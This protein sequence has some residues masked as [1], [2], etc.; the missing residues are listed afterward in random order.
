MTE[1]QKKILMLY[2]KMEKYFSKKSYIDI[3]LYAGIDEDIHNICSD[4]V[5][6]V[7]EMLDIDAEECQLLYDAAYNGFP[8]ASTFI[9]IDTN[10]QEKITCNTIEEFILTFFSDN[11][12]EN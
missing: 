11:K 5:D 2:D 9:D 1:R 4:W 8:F 6:L 10:T 3:D 12:K 7:T